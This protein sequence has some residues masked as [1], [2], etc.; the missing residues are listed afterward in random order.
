MNYPEYKHKR[1]Y[2]GTRVSYQSSIV[3]K[4]SEQIYYLK[5][6]G[7]YSSWLIKRDFTFNPRFK[8]ITLIRNKY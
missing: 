1:K 3:S 2:Y 8:T 7:F 4:S 6:S 5:Y